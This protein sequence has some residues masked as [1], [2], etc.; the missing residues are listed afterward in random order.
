MWGRVGEEGKQ[1]SIIGRYSLS[2]PP[3]LSDKWQQVEA[4]CVEIGP[5]PA[6]GREAHHTHC[7][8]S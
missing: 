4:S 7:V 6:V 8:A 2:L 5:L 3:S 1:W